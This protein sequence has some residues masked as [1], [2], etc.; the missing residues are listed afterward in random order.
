[1]LQG[2]AGVGKTRLSEEA[3][4]LAERAGKRVE[5]AVGHPAT[6]AIPLGALAHV[7]PGEIV[8]DVGVGDDERTALFHAARAALGRLAGGD[9]LV[10]LVDDLDLLDDTSVAVL[11]P[12]VVSRSVFLIGTVRAGRTASPRLTSLHRDGH[13]VRLDL[14]P[15]HDDELGALLHRALDGPV[16]TRAQAELSRLSGGNLQMLTELVQGA[17]ERG[18]LVDVNGVWDL[19]APLPTT[20][21]LEELVAEHLA[22]VDTAGI[23]V[24]EVLAVCERFGLQD[25]E[26]ANGAATLEAL[27]AKR[28]VTV[29]TSGRRTALRLAHPLY[30]EVLRAGLPPLRLRRIHQELADVVEGHGARRREDVVHVAMWR[31]ASGGRVSGEQLLRAARLALIGRDSD[32]AVELVDAIT[33]ERKIDPVDRAEVLAEA[34]ALQGHH[35]EVDRIIGEV[36]DGPL[37]DNQVIQLAR[38]RA[39]TRFYSARDLEGALAAYEA[40]CERVVDPEARAAVMARRA[41]MLAGAGRPSEALRVLDAVGEA[42][43]P[44]PTSSSSGR[45]RRAWSC[46]GVWTRPL[47]SRG[48]VPHSKPTFRDGW[49]VAASPCTSSTKDMPSATRGGSGRQG[50]CWSR[51]ATAPGRP[52]P[53]A[54]GCGSRWFSQRSPGTQ[55]TPM[56]RFDASVPSPRRPRWSVRTRR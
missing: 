35:D 44:E 8:H 4:R 46:W 2:P 17:R 47:S 16:S 32:L 56:R 55:V 21:A 29:V 28:L 41:N 13:L 23:A 40:A 25:L 51:R 34:H 49:P 14:E 9:R 3:L 50:H 45:V 12:L 7:L 20:T 24:L 11:V 6:K 53:W 31:V 43:D 37:T 38:R 54:P 30:G 33:D 26:A 42:K 10:L 15:L 48:R 19:I 52:M 18:A 36:W 5:R 22:S 27:E 39:E 1:M